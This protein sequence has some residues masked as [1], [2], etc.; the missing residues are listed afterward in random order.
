MCESKTRQW[1]KNSTGQQLPLADVQWLIAWFTLFQ[2]AEDH[3]FKLSLNQVEH[4]TVK[5]WLGGGSSRVRRIQTRWPPPFLSWQST[6]FHSV[7]IIKTGTMSRILPERCT[8]VIRNM[9]SSDFEKIKSFCSKR[10][11]K[12]VEM[13]MT[14]DRRDPPFSGENSRHHWN[15]Q[16]LCYTD[17]EVK[18]TE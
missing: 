10:T 18:A 11:S 2:T 4:M 16:M 17:M 6:Y 12:V 3:N 15:L 9:R 8:L 5:S 14:Y 1:A 13:A 7:L